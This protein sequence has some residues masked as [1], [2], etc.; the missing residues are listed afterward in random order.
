MSDALSGAHVSSPTTS[1]PVQG[2]GRA[3]TIAPVGARSSRT[4]SSG[5][6]GASTSTRAPSL[7]V[8][9]GRIITYAVEP[10][11]E[12]GGRPLLAAVCHQFGQPLTI[13]DV[14]LEPPAEG[15]GTVRVTYC[16]LCHSDITFIG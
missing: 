10:G 7:A 14:R 13:E 3:S 5:N 9:A 6:G 12:A 16:G 8:T 1:S 2:L 4:T 11:T 15:Q